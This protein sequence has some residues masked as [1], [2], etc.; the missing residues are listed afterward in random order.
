MDIRYHVSMLE[1]DRHLYTV[2]MEVDRIDRPVLDLVMP[3]WTP[4]SYMI[5]EYPRHVQGFSAHGTAGPLAWQKL[6]K[7]SWRITPSGDLA[8][9]ISYQVYA[10]ELTVRTNHL[11]GTHG[12][13]NGAALFMY[14]DGTKDQPATVTVE[15]PAGWQVTTALP[16]DDDAARAGKKPARRGG[17]AAESA[18]F[19][20]RAR[21]FDELCDSPFECG[22]QRL[23]EFSHA[24]IG[25][26]IA[27]WGRPIFDSI[28]EERLVNDVRRIVAEGASIFGELPYDAYTFL[29]HLSPGARGGLEHS[30][31][32]TLHANPFVFRH[33]EK[34]EDFLTLVAHEH[35]HTWNIKRIRPE[36]LGPFDYTREAYTRSLWAVEGITDY[37]DKLNVRRAGLISPARYL[38]MVADEIKELRDIPGR[39]KTSLEESSFDAWIKLYRPDETTPNTTVSYYLKGGLVALILD[40]E[41]RQRTGGRRSLDDVMRALW[42]RYRLRGE[43]YPDGALENVFADVAGGPVKELFD[44]Y[45]RGTVELD[46]ERH[47]ALAGLRLVEGPAPSPASATPGT[48]PAPGGAEGTRRKPVAGDLGVRT[49]SAADRAVVTHVLEGRPSDGLL[50]PGD[51]LVALDGY[52]L[53][54][55]NLT[56]M[57]EL[58]GPGTQ[59]RLTLFRR[60]SLMTV[61]VRLGQPLATKLRIE[62]RND[63]SPEAHRIYEGWLGAAWEPTPIATALPLR[64]PDETRP[65]RQKPA[66]RPARRPAA[67]PAKRKPTTRRR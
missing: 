12:F 56:E 19:R 54:D 10:H 4:G 47:L 30:S 60:E 15:T 61:P 7:H 29:L 63:A 33:P 21:S 51:E 6:D 34:Y 31:S 57:L 18:V 59:V 64:L 3:V 52:R 35:F 26:R 40:L 23:I 1:P 32:S 65:S 48:P 44:A 67:K 42:Q 20:F 2:V 39:R 5:R 43:G 37:Y 58:A 36:V 8:A 27:I 53:S 25:H 55:R 45:V 41:L 62:Q 24:E 13:F 28:D 22:T 46:W 66:K 16:A 11:D 50:Y 17:A 49:R 9:T 38:E 14:V